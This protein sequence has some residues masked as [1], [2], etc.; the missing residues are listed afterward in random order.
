[1]NR[2]ESC[3]KKTNSKIIISITIAS[4]IL[5]CIK[6]LFP[7]FEKDL[8]FLFDIEIEIEIAKLR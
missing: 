2:I 7:I 1:M 5:S 8:M 6:I 4:A 3:V